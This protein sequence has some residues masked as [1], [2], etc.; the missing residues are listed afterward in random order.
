MRSPNER[1]RRLKAVAVVASQAYICA[2]DDDDGSTLRRGRLA[3]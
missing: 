3:I 2:P 1:K